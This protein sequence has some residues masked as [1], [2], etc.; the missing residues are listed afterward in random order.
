MQPQVETCLWFEQLTSILQISNLCFIMSS[1]L[2]DSCQHPCDTHMSHRFPCLTIEIH[3]LFCLDYAGFN[4]QICEK[5]SWIFSLVGMQ[6]SIFTGLSSYWQICPTNH[7]TSELSSGSSTILG[8]SVLGWISSWI[9]DD[10][11]IMSTDWTDVGA[12]F[13]PI[14]SDPSRNLKIEHSFKCWNFLAFKNSEQK[15]SKGSL[16]FNLLRYINNS[17]SFNI[18]NQP[19]AMLHGHD[20]T[21]IDM[22]RWHMTNS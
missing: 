6:L 20:N 17:L 2:E 13:C 9:Q 4:C 15:L 21:N 19:R 14:G 1:P 22:T 18:L 5:Y 8:I 3:V 7:P 12:I 16:S 10:L 11:H